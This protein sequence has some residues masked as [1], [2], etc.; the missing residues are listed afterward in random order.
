MKKVEIRNFFEYLVFRI[1]NI[2]H[3]NLN[4]TLRNSRPKK[5]E[6]FIRSFIKAYA[7]YLG[8]DE[9]EVLNRYYDAR[10]KI[11]SPDE[12]EFKQVEK[13]DFSIYLRFGLILLAILF[14]IYFI[15]RIFF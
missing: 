2:S 12:R 4:L 6:F 7:N 14:F 9:R 10:P 1:N 13:K 3:S 11:D 5:S 8:L 15:I